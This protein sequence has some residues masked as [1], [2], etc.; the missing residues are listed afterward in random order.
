MPQLRSKAFSILKLRLT[1]VIK[2]SEMALSCLL[3]N[4]KK[5]DGVGMD[6]DNEIMGKP[7]RKKSKGEIGMVNQ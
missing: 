5:C 7:C 4:T 6:G 2:R 3:E 1:Y